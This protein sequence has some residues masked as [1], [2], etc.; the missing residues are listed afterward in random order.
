MTMDLDATVCEA[1]GHHGQGAAYGSTNQ[2]G[3]HPLLA[4]RT[5][6]RRMD[7]EARLGSWVTD[8]AAHLSCPFTRASCE[9]SVED[10]VADVGGERRGPDGQDLQL[11][12]R[13]AVEKAFTCAEGERCDVGAQLIDE[14]GG[15]VL[16]DRGGAAGDG[17]VAISRRRARL[18]QSGVDAVGDEREGGPPCIVSGS[19][20]WWVSTNAGGMVG[21][22]LTHQPRQL[23]SQP[24][25]G[26]D[27]TLGLEADRRRLLVDYLAGYQ[28]AQLFARP[29]A[30]PSARTNGADQRAGYWHLPVS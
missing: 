11:Q 7:Q 24:V 28:H 25:L 16:V 2:L 20:G 15:Q 6:H 14:A 22:V 27:R 12:R 19:R 8:P 1:H 10:A 4:T 23:G 3:Y 30:S 29:A 21:R 17:H 9:G 13:D 18:L 5:S 26:P